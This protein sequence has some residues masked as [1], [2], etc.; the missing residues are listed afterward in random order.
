MRAL[1]TAATGMQAQQL[2]IDVI[3]NN[4]AN[5]NTDGF[6]SS[7]AQF[8]D[9][10]YQTM[11]ISGAATSAE[12]QSPTGLQ[13]GLGARPAATAR[14]FEQ[15]DLKNTDNPLD[16]AIQGAGLFQVLTPG[17]EIAYT[18]NGAFK[19][20]N[21]GTLVNS[22]GFE[23]YPRITVPENYRGIE[24]AGDGTI[25]ALVA[26]QQAPVNLGQ[27]E[28]VTVVNTGSLEG[29]GRN[30]YRINGERPVPGT[31]GTENRG[32]IQQGF[33]EAS[34]VK[35]VEEMVQMILGQRA[36]EANSKVIQTADHMMEEANRLR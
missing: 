34:N 3:A 26:G 20:N 11:K 13:V 7:D 6:K 29:M 8:A 30:L 4:L 28:L 15:G 10:M 24:I 25:T 21:E 32:T 2:K 14:D 18:R 5:V 27:L 17:D 12:T 1:Y 9:L 16:V 23:V 33:L 36:Y 35:V 19:I 31:P 22:D